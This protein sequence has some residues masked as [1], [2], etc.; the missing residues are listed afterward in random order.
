L[1]RELDEAAAARAKFEKNIFDKDNKFASSL[2]EIKSYKKAPVVVIS[3]VLATFV[4]IQEPTILRKLIRAPDGT[5]V[6]PEDPKDLEKLWIFLAS[7]LVVAA[8]EET[9]ISRLKSYQ[10]F[11]T[12]DFSDGAAIAAGHF[13]ISGNIIANVTADA[14][15]RSS[16]AAVILREWLLMNL[17]SQK[18]LLDVITIES[19]SK[20]AGGVSDALLDAQAA[21]VKKHCAESV[22]R[23]LK[24][25]I[26]KEAEA[27]K[28]AKASLTRDS[29]G[30][31]A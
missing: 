22:D 4:L 20:N 29:K 10:P 19:S 25:E 5:Y 28:A 16:Y 30:K 12:Y 23:I 3:V 18:K 7:K 24:L 21:K 14:A 17:A 11:T 2:V 13:I 8:G 26:K 15:K 1:R 31:H 9:T 27:A 6:M